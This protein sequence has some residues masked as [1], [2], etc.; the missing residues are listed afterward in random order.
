MS[1]KSA[2]GTCG[3]GR[4]ADPREA[5]PGCSEAASLSRTE[6]DEDKAL[7]FDADKALAFDADVGHG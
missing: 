2:T 4:P 1:A 7:A 3:K 5:I 6:F